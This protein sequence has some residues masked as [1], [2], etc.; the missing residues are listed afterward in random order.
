[1]KET[2]FIRQERR[3]NAEFNRMHG[4]SK[5]VLVE[6]VRNVQAICPPRPSRQSK[7]DLERIVNGALNLGDAHPIKLAMQAALAS[8]REHAR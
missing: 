5:P 6:A 7:A 8:A 2:A 1:M 3:L 4:W